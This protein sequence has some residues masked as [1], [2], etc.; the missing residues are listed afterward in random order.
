MYKVKRFA[1]AKNR[2]GWNGKNDMNKLPKGSVPHFKP[3]YSRY[4]AV[5][6]DPGRPNSY[7]RDSKITKYSDKYKEDVEELTQSQLDRLNIYLDH[8]NSGKFIFDDDDNATYEN[9]K[10]DDI[11]YYKWDT[12]THWLQKESTEDYLVYSK[13]ISG[14]KRLTYRIYRPK[15]IGNKWVCDIEIS[16]C[17]S[18]TYGDKSYGKP[19]NTLESIV[20]Y[21]GKDTKGQFSD[22]NE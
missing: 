8:L 17:G 18:H 15:K 6:V 7:I 13:D 21:K 9:Y 20:K 12:C 10:K 1:M 22:T 16:R 5:W 3:R 19:K 14:S 2:R 11:I 4:N